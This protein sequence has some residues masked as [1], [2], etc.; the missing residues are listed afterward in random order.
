M[1]SLANKLSKLRT[2]VSA[3]EDTVTK[4]LLYINTVLLS[5]TACVRMMDYEAG[6]QEQGQLFEVSNDLGKSVS[7]STEDA[8]SDWEIYS[9]EI[10]GSP[11]GDREASGG[12]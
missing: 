4:E 2:S 12:H 1:S 9:D 7:S 8:A 5:V 6:E 11:D 3:L 10:C